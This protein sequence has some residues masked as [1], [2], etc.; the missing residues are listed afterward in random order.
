MKKSEPLLPQ[1]KAVLVPVQFT[2]LAFPASL[3]VFNALLDNTLFLTITFSS[4][5]KNY[6][7]V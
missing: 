3:Y 5:L 1:L 2:Q 6:V 4:I 7:C